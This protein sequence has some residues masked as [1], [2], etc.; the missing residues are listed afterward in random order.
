V[1]FLQEVLDGTLRNAA[2]HS[3][4]QPQ[5]FPGTIFVE[6]HER[7]G[8]SSGKLQGSFNGMLSK[9]QTHGRLQDATKKMLI[10]ESGLLRSL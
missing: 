3:P 4:G 7:L 1:Y 10:C 9:K 5:A 2:R 8:T 6:A